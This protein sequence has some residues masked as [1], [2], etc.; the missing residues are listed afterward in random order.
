MDWRKWPYWLRGGLIGILIG[1][2]IFFLAIIFP[3]PIFALF[4]LFLFLLII[5]FGIAGLCDKI[6]FLRDEICNIEEGFSLT[7]IIILI[8][9]WFVIGAIIRLIYGKIKSK[10]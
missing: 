5:I 10:K 1:I 7:Q 9:S 3:N 8:L 6:P 2:L 4:E